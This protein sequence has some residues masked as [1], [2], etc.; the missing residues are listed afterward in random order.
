MTKFSE[1]AQR[2]N[3][4]KGNAWNRYITP[5][6]VALRSSFSD[7][8]IKS[9]F[10]MYLQA[11]YDQHVTGLVKSASE[12]D[13]WIRGRISLCEELLAFPETIERQIMI[14]EQA[15]KQEDS[16]GQAGY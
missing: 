10:L 6:L 16:R 4:S 14:Q 3:E 11:V 13:D 2:Q 5:R 7:E 12:K 1:Q 8:A 15:K 9:G